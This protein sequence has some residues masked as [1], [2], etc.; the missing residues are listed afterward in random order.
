MRLVS[1]SRHGGDWRIGALEHK[2]KIIDLTEAGLPPDMLG[3]VELGAQGMEQARAAVSRTDVVPIPLAE[4]K[5]G[6]P[7]TRLRRN[8]FCVGKNYMKHAHEFSGSGFDNSASVVPQYPVIFTK[9]PSAVIGP[10]S[11]IPAYLDPT[12]STDYE[13]ELAVVIGTGGRGIARADAPGHVFGYTIVN[14]VTARELQKQH[15]QWFIGKSIDGFCPMGPCLA[16]RDE[17]DGLARPSLRTYVND[18]LRQHGYLEDLIFDVPSLI[19][20]ISRTIELHPG[21]IIATGT[22]EGVGIGFDP[23]KYL[24]AGDVVRIAIDG[25]GELSNPVD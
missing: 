20:T 11:P 4:V 6:A 24:K 21:D 16:T 12:A 17:V 10:E 5:L 1:F 19:E 13:G 3:L 15:G 18:E 22:P 14:D 23:P 8:I 7:F 25:I 9:P 2:T